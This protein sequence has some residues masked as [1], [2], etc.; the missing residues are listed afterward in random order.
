MGNFRIVIEAVGGHGVDRTKKDGEKVDF[1][2]DGEFSPDA[3]AQRFVKEMRRFG[4][5]VDTAIITHWPETESEVKDD[6]I[7]G[8][9]KGN[10]G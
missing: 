5:S 4:N 10:F 3:L 6:L 8:I 2:A 9:R 1:N 7:T